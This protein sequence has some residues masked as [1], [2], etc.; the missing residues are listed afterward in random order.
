MY[1]LVLSPD[2]NQRFR[3][4]S[5]MASPASDLLKADWDKWGEAVK[6]SG[7]SVD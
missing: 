4:E 1:T 7:A 3:S 5:T 2:A 6:L